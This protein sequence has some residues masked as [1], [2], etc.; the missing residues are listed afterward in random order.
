M[1]AAVPAEDDFIGRDPVAFLA[2]LLELQ[3]ETDVR[4]ARLVR[5]ALTLDPGHPRHWILRI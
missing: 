3:K 1:G 2:K 4:N 5:G